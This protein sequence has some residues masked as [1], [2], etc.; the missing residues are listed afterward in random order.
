MFQIWIMLELFGVMHLLECHG[1]EN[2]PNLE[3]GIISLAKLSVMHLLEQQT[4]ISRSHE[5][6]IQSFARLI[7]EYYKSDSFRQN[8]TWSATTRQ[9]L[10]QL[11]QQ[12]AKQ[13]LCS[14]GRYQPRR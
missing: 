1:T 7:A 10:Q 13:Q 6:T 11:R 14:N 2:V 3:N 9:L 4:H 12:N 8:P 5:A